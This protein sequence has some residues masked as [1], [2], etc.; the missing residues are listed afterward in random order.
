MVGNGGVFLGELENL[1]DVG[2]FVENLSEVLLALDLLSGW[3]DFDLLDFKLG[4][5]EFAVLET[6]LESFQTFGIDIYEKG[7]EQLCEVFIALRASGYLIG[8]IWICWND[9]QR[10][11]FGFVAQGAVRRFSGMP[12][13]LHQI[14]ILFCKYD[15]TFVDFRRLALLTILQ[16]LIESWQ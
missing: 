3:K 1:C 14:A 4:S 15:Q 9:T 10:G 13:L 8:I 6:Y 12:E 16:N 5:F 2:E 11:S 7:F